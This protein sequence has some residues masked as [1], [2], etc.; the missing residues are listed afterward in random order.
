LELFREGKISSGKAG[1]LLGMRKIDFIDLLGQY[2][3]PFLDLPS[4]ELEADV[5]VAM[6]ASDKENEG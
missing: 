2:E 1:E 4:G 3:I 6:K 5:R